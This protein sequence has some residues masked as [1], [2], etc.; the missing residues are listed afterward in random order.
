MNIGPGI[1]KT[2]VKNNSQRIAIK[3]NKMQRNIARIIEG[4]EMLCESGREETKRGRVNL[5]EDTKF[6]SLYLKNLALIGQDKVQDAHVNTARVF[7]QMTEP[8]FTTDEL[9]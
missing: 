5:D 8:T 3:F 1:E 9:K 7:V 2:A 6:S 4:W